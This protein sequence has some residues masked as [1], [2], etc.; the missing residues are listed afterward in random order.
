MGGYIGSAQPKQ[1][2]EHLYNQQSH[3]QVSPLFPPPTHPTS[4]N[5]NACFTS[6][7][8]QTLLCSPRLNSQRLQIHMSSISEKYGR[9]FRA[10]DDRV[11]GYLGRFLRRAK[12]G[13]EQERQLLQVLQV[14]IRD[15]LRRTLDS[16]AEVIHLTELLKESHARMTDITANGDR[17]LEGVLHAYEERLRELK[18]KVEAEANEKILA[19]QTKF[20]REKIDLEERL[21]F[22]ESEMNHRLKTTILETEQ[23]I[24]EREAENQ[25]KLKT[26][27][28][29]AESASESFKHQLANLTSELQA[30]KRSFLELQDSMTKLKQAQ[31]EEKL[32]VQQQLMEVVQTW[33]REAKSR[34]EVSE[35]A[36]TATS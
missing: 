32:K 25:A 30:E 29:E 7:L 17:H 8:T 26:Q 12:Q 24:Y 28:R 13:P 35:V 15:L 10:V 34:E 18:A 33:E 36:A 20:K 16:E 23:R 6:H 11:A 5:S 4:L 1:V 9:E 22:A 2:Y 27:A 14:E 21:A 19:A 3:E 31:S